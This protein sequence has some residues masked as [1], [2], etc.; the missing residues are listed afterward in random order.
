VRAF[1]LYMRVER[2]VPLRLLT[3]P[4]TDLAAVLDR[5]RPADEGNTVWLHA[6]R[7]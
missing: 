1:S 7:P 5:R 4:F 6:R 2:F 3:I